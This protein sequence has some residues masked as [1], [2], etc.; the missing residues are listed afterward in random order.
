MAITE[1][2]VAATAVTASLLEPCNLLH[3]RDMQN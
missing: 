3:G 1:H 2:P